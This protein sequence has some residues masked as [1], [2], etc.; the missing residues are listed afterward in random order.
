MNA[1]DSSATITSSASPMQDLLAIQKAAFLRDDTPTL[2]QRRADLLKL[3]SAILA[4]QPEIEAAL[5]QDFGHRSTHETAIMEILPLIQGINYQRRNLRRWM[6]PQRRHVPMTFQPARAWVAY[7]PLGVVG[8]MAPWNYPLSLAL[9]PLATAIAAGNRAMIKPSE[10]APASSALLV[11]LVAQTFAPEQVA[12]VTGDDGVGRD[13]ASLPFDH[14]VFT[15]STPVGRAVMRAASENLVPV[16]LE[17]GGKSPVIVEPGYPLAHAA[18]AIAYGK[19]ANSGQTCIAPDY[20]LVHRDSLDAF[21]GEFDQAVRALYPAGPASADYTSVINE[22]H[23][24]RLRAL[25]D[26]AR[27]QGAQM[28]EVGANPADAATRPHHIAPTVVLG[29]TARMRVMQEEIFG[30]VL[31]VIGYRDLDEAI[32]FVNARARPL[33]LYYFGSRGASRSKVL[34]STTSGNVTINKHLDALRAGR[35]AVRRRRF[36]RYRRLPRHR[37]LQGAEP[38]QRHLPARAVESERPAA[39]SVR[40]PG[41]TDPEVTAAVSGQGCCDDPHKATEHRRDNRIGR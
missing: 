21:V 9:M 29:A 18:K 23:F 25:L 12:V 16:T 38:C 8:V 10:F 32:A 34:A 41:D 37:G 35:P 36:Q 7:Q 11:D 39:A 28:R 1:I 27:S 15:G 33:A 24:R 22:R 6:R 13:F 31:P 20:V 5:R 26:D 19:L 4:R 3:K 2:A 30:P 40:G 17:L 14:L